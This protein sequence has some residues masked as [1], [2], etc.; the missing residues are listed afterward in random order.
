MKYEQLKLKEF[1]KVEYDISEAF[2]R[3]EEGLVHDLMSELSWTYE[4]SNGHNFST[5][6]DHHKEVDHWRIEQLQRLE[7]Y[8]KNSIVK[9]SPKFAEVNGKIEELL[10]SSYSSGLSAEERRILEALQN[11]YSAINSSSVKVKPTY[12]LNTKK[13]EALVKATTDDLKKAE[14]AVLRKAHDSYRSIIF[15]A[16]VG[17]DTGTLS[18]QEA[19]DLATKDFLA[20]GI[21]CIKYKNGSVHRIADYASMAVRTASKRA[22][23]IG[24]GEK[25]REYGCH[26][27]LVGNRGAEQPCE[28]CAPWVGQVLVDDVYSGGTRKEAK[29]N[30]YMLLSQAIANGLFHPRC[31]DIT[32]TFFPEV[33]EPPKKLS[34]DEIREIAERSAEKQRKNAAKRK[35]EKY[36]RLA[37]YSETKEHKKQYKSKA[38]EWKKEEKGEK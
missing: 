15:D 10:R 11:G 25:R 16:A 24:E 9:Y 28:C 14:L 23:L 20:A 31:K 22:Y 13:L 1:E 3:I 2:K 4:K 36:E 38:K 30:G 7:Q 32:T 21:K 19:T 12:N 37:K 33:D 26:F 17:L 5:T 34:K 27:V 8:R 6:L 35:V 18:Y 29:E